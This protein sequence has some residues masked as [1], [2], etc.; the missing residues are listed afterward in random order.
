MSKSKFEIEYLNWLQQL[1]VEEDDTV[2]EEIQGELDFVET[3][4]YI[5]YELDRIN[6][7]VRKIVTK[8]YIKII[9]AAAAVILLI[10]ASV[11]YFS[12]HVNQP[13]HSFRT[14]NNRRKTY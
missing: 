7:P 8:S 14:N 9:A 1:D 4:D 13:I 12:E 3:W 10:L 11:N 5:S 6:P 2:W